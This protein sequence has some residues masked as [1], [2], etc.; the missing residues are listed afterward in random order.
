MRVQT[1][2]G[3]LRAQLRQRRRLDLPHSLAREREPPS[4]LLEGETVASTDAEAQTEHFLL[5][6]RQRSQQIAEPVADLARRDPFHDGFTLWV[7]DDVAQAHVAIRVE[8]RVHA[9]RLR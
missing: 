4:D 9:D 1:L 7:G 6:L 2:C 3:R 8:R 5:P